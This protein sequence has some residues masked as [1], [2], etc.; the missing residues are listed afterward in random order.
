MADNDNL[1]QKDNVTEDEDFTA[2]PQLGKG[3]SIYQLH[4]NKMVNNTSL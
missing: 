4:L 2:D 3:I 1:T